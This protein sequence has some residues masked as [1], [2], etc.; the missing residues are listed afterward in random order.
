MDVLIEAAELAT[1]LTETGAGRAARPDG[2]PV[3]IDVRWSLGGPSR[4]P[5]F[6]SGHI[7]GAHWVDL[8]T[9]LSDHQATERRDSDPPATDGDVRGRGR[10]PLPAP[11]AFEAAMRRAGV[12]TDSTVIIYDADNALAASRL[13]WMLADAGHR[14]IR[15]LNGGYAAWLAMGGPVETGAGEPIPPG[16]FRASPG[17]LPRIDAAE[18]AE[19]ISAGEAGTIIDVRG[20]ER[21]AGES[22]PIDPVAGHI[23]GAI[24][25]PSMINVGSDGRFLS[26]A[27]IAANFGT[28][29][30][31]DS[32]PVVYCG[33]GITAAHTAL[34]RTV[35]GLSMPRLYPGSWSDWITDPSRPVSTGDQP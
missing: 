32:E 29:D 18:L 13:W 11:A 27:E 22:E 5:D 1:L 6:L 10:H 25:V 24:N 30:R 3:L 20:P 14:Q 26:A 34:A 8:E 17:Q 4:L 23:P 16:D 15:V 19:Q 12:D 21:Y 35:A 9:E 33:S 7:P 2:A 31:S 28:A